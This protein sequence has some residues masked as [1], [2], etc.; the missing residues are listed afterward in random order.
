M[1]SQSPSTFHPLTSHSGLLLDMTSYAMEYPFDQRGSAVPPSSPLNLLHN[2]SPLTDG[3]VWETEKVLTLCKSTVHQQVK[4][5]HVINTAITNP[6][7]SPTQA[8]MTKYNLSPNQ[9]FLWKLEISKFWVLCYHFSFP[10]SH[11][12]ESTTHEH[13]PHCFRAWFMDDHLLM[14]SQGSCLRVLNFFVIFTW[15]SLLR[16]E[17]NQA[18]PGQFFFFFNRAA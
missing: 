18:Q 6:K 9:Q 1:S 14:K 3:V 15:Q 5:P 16:E 10:I 7:H 12:M 4:H 13:W 8:T 17:Q 2:P 11:Q